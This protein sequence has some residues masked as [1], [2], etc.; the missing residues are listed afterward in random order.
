MKHVNTMQVLRVI[1]LW[2]LLLQSFGKARAQGRRK[3]LRVLRFVELW[4][5]QLQPFGEASPWTGKQVHLVWL[6]ELWKL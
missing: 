4:K 3:P 1:G 6:D 2:Q 5:L